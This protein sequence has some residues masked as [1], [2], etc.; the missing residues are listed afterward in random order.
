MNWIWVNRRRVG[1]LMATA[2]LL[3]ALAPSVSHALQA[4]RGIGWV[5]VCTTQGSRWIQAQADPQPEAPARLQALEHCL[6]CSLHAPATGLPPDEAPALAPASHGSA[7]AAAWLQSPRTLAVWRSA[8]A[9]APPA[10]A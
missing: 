2:L 1:W 3:A 6:Y 9:R 7:P 5:E 10:R 4:S 8:L